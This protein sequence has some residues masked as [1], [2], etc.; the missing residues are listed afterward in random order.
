[1]DTLLCPKCIVFDIC[2]VQEKWLVPSCPLFRGFTAL[3]G[4]ILDVKYWGA[5]SPNLNIRGAGAP[6]PPP[7]P[8]PPR[9]LRP[10]ISSFKPQRRYNLYATA[11][12]QI[13]RECLP[14]IVP[15]TVSVHK[16]ATRYLGE[17][18]PDPQTTPPSFSW[19]PGD[20]R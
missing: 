7:P 8:S 10:C 4:I 12:E 1:M 17:H 2:S 11:V 14:Q 9:L 19:I 5:L 20:G 18:P 3:D 13:T 6:P 15:K 16:N